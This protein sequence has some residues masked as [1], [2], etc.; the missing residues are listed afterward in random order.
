MTL[1]A[2]LLDLD[3]TLVD[4][5]QA[6]VDVTQSTLAALG[7]PPAD[8]QAIKDGI[9]LPLPVALAQ[10]LGTGV[11]GA[12]DAVEIYR[13]H[14]H[15]TVT[16]RLAQL[17]YPG[18][19]EGLQAL[20]AAGLRLGVVTGK[21]QAGADGTVDGAGLRKYIE[22]TLG[23]TSVPNPKPAPD[24]ALE[25][26]KRM[27]VAPAAAVVVGDAVHDL[28]MARRA[29][30]RSIAVTY[31]AQPQATL[32]AERPTHIAHTFPDVVRIMRTLAIEGA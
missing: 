27:N 30:M 29:G 28:E 10:L 32:E 11:A 6:I 17:V 13:V 26:A 22:V 31:G 7:R 19:H 15:A 8:V 23:Y 25:A 14:W 24:L 4:T 9:G 1:Q 21:A 5:P 12:A 3:G 18:V 16:P 2:V 20:R